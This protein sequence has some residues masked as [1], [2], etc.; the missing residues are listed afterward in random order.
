MLEVVFKDKLHEKKG[1]NVEE[2]ILLARQVYI[3][4]KALEEP[5]L[6]RGCPRCNHQLKC[7]PCSAR[8]ITEMAKTSA[9]RIRISAATDRMD[10]TVGG[11]GS[12]S[13]M[14]SPGGE[15][16]CVPQSA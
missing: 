9:G 11:W 7:G 8:I 5:G 2:H 14:T 15:L 12:S 13:G 1:G 3:K 6:T 4:P 10:R 16:T